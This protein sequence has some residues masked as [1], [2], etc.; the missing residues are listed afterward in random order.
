M[1]TKK[2]IADLHAQLTAD[3]RQYIT[4]MM[5]AARATGKTEQQITASM[6][7][8]AGS[9]DKLNL[10]QNGT[11]QTANRTGVV[12]QQLGYQMQ[13]F[14]VQ[15]SSGQSA[16][17]AFSQQGSQMAGVFGPGGAMFGAALAI[18]VLVTQLF[19]ASKQA[20]D[21]TEKI[22]DLTRALNQLAEARQGRFFETVNADEQL[23]GYQ[24]LLDQNIAKQAKLNEEISKQA[25]LV[26]YANDIAAGGDDS[27]FADY[28]T[29]QN[30]RRR[31]P[32]AEALAAYRRSRGLSPAELQAEATTALEAAQTKLLNLQKEALELEKNIGKTR[33]D[34]FK[35]RVKGTEE[36][37]A[38]LEKQFDTL[39]AGQKKANDATDQA[40]NEQAKQREQIDRLAESYRLIADP[41][42]KYRD[43]IAEVR[44]LESRGKLTTNEAAAA[45]DALTDAMDKVTR[46]QINQ[47]LDQ[48]FD[49]LDEKSKRNLAAYA[50]RARAFT[51]AMNGMFQDVSNTAGDAFAD[52]VLKGENAFG[53]LV[54]IIARSVIRIAAQMA[55]I[56]PILNGLFGGFGGYVAL[57]TF[58][59]GAAAAGGA[60]ASASSASFAG[61]FAEGGTLQ[62]GT[63][64]IAGENGPEPI[65]AGN[66]PLTV[67]PNGG[68]A[69]G[70]GDTFNFT[71]NIGAGVTREQLLP[72]LKQQERAVI[73]KIADNR[74]RGGGLAFG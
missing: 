69:G 1:A 72:I 44:D 3:V 31:N 28:Q 25:R 22:D 64:G 18:G 65:F 53:A 73:A 47:D 9:F 10:A 35:E 2:Q 55:I 43:Q 74:R 16:L 49:S 23:R 30:F 21:T 41:L 46:A 5:A 6:H 17:V 34:L 42:K 57:P 40:M 32:D 52:L 4:D 15:V 56:N 29:K 13:D 68:G 19:N 8:A 62:P 20:K 51:A 70:G 14:A 39:V 50:E 38:A 37:N 71:Y 24:Q 33:D 7:K 54:D 67:M 63:W 11:R 27:F 60:A 59:G 36:V 48:F 45:I 26:Q 58:Y 66:S 12:I 61:Y